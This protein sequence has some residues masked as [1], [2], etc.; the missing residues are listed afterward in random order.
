MLFI[1]IIFSTVVYPIDILLFNIF[2]LSDEDS[3]IK[4]ENYNKRQ[5]I[6][7]SLKCSV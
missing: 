4:G 5:R 2:K 7:V 1:Q 3:E 6:V